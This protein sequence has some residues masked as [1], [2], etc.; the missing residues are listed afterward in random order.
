MDLRVL[1]TAVLLTLCGPAYAMPQSAPAD[2]VLARAEARIERIRKADVVVV[3]QNS[4]GT[5][6]RNATVNAVQT[7]HA[8]LFDCAALAL[9]QYTDAARET[10]YEKRFSALFNFATVLT[11]WQ[12]T[13]PEQERWMAIGTGIPAV[14]CVRI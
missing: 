12:D 7:K 3:V 13:E 14:F 6:V 10:L 2:P 4:G 8:F 11:Y 1:V 5:P 9:L